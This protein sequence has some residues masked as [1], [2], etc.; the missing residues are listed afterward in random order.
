MTKDVFVQIA[1]TQHSYPKRLKETQHAP[2]KLFIKGEN[3]LEKPSIAIVG[4]RKASREGM[5]LAERIAYNLAESGITIVSGLAQGIDGAAHRGALK[6]GGSTIGVIASSLEEAFFFPRQHLQLAREM[7]EKGGTIV[8]EHKA[9]TP[10]R[11][12]HFVARNRIIA[13][14]S[15]GVLVVEA[16]EKSGA[17]ITANFAKSYGR[18]VFSVPGSPLAKNTKGTNDLLRQ[19]AVITESGEDILKVLKRKRGFELPKK[20]SKAPFSLK[21]DELVVYRALQES[22]ASAEELM[23][24][25]ELPMAKLLALLMDLEIKGMVKNIGQGKYVVT[26]PTAND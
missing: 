26:A 2:E 19:G 9:A 17:L 14:L 22:K 7:V 6:A 10:A 21:G 11:K 12:H 25:I 8:S 15:L 4:T 23:E 1:K 24:N 3:I 18:M 16:P 20:N 5:E 13:G